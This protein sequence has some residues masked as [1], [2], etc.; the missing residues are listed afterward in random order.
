MQGLEKADH[1]WKSGTISS[2]LSSSPFSFSANGG[3][4]VMFLG[5]A[6]N[7]IPLFSNVRIGGTMFSRHAAA[8]ED[9]LEEAYILI[10][11]AQQLRNA[12]LF[13]PQS[14]KYVA[15]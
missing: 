7:R 12:A 11:F 2:K 6:S 4:C 1:T 9:A 10:S 5:S 3:S 15:I 14:K 8:I 13:Y